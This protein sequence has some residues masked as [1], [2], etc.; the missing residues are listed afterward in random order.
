[1]TTAGVSIN[2]FCSSSLQVIAIAM[3]CQRVASEEVPAMVAGGG[4]EYISMVQNDKHN[5]L[6]AAN[7][8]L[9]KN[10]PG[11]YLSMIE[12]ADIVAQDERALISQQCTAAAQKAGRFDDEIVPFDATILLKDKE[13]GA[14]NETQ[15]SPQG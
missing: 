11:S 3:T 7:D 2:R 1:V 4:V 8:W 13:T 6:H 12:T 10:K 14:F 15:V 9:M 5:Q